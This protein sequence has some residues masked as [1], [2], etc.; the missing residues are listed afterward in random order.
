[1]DGDEQM[2][3]GV[4]SEGTVKQLEGLIQNFNAE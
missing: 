4:M 1:M 2:Y 3:E